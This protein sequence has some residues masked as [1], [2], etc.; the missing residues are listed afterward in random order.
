M[1]ETEQLAGVEMLVL[2]FMQTRV[3]LSVIC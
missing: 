2:C 3:R 1:C